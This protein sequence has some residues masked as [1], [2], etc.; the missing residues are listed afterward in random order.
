MKIV[1]KEFEIV[2]AGRAVLHKEV[3]E[4]AR[5]QQSQQDKLLSLSKEKSP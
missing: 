4:S 3:S 1:T 2:A 5:A